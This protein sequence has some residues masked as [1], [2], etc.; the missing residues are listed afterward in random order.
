MAR[1]P[2]PAESDRG[3]SAVARRF[4][5]AAVVCMAAVVVVTVTAGVS[6]LEG[7]RVYQPP[8]AALP[9]GVLALAAT[10]AL[11]APMV[12]W[13]SR[14]VHPG[15][16]TGLAV[17][18]VGFLLPWWAGWSSVPDGVGARAVAA[19]PLVAAGLSQAAVRSSSSRS[20]SS[21]GTNRGLALVYGFCGAA[22]VVL[23]VAY[24][25]FADPACVRSCAATAWVLGDGG[26][27]AR[28]LAGAEVLT[29]VATAMSAVLAARSWP[30]RTARTE[31]VATV[32]SLALLALFRYTRFNDWT[33]PEHDPW[34]YAMLA[35]AFVLPLLAVA[36]A[37]ARI[38]RTRAAVDQVLA[39]LGDPRPSTAAPDGTFAEVQVEVQDQGRWVDLQGLPV[40]EPAPG[41]TTVHLVGSDARAAMRIVLAP[42]AAGDDLAARLTPARRLALTN[43]GLAT[44]TRAH[45]AEVQASQQRVVARTDTERHRIERDLH[46]GAQQRL[47]SA[48]LLL[49]S[50]RNRLPPADATVLASAE[51]QIHEALGQLRR[52]SHGTFPAVLSDDGLPA[53]LEEL[54]T[55][56][57]VAVELDLTVGDGPL[58]QG[59]TA[60]AYATVD[61]ALRGI[62]REPGATARVS[63]SERAGLLT[64]VV[65][66]RGGGVLPSALTSQDAAD[67]VGALGGRYEVEGCE[68]DVRLTAVV[69]CAS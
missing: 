15:V 4:D 33:S 66:A 50:A 47:V 63:L 24:Q 67:R 19:T 25:P 55:E 65:Q 11:A 6:A 31:A 18:A 61:A 9:S 59:A 38:S 34:P 53:A 32:S 5:A 60:A 58:R 46:D 49:G 57:D 12:A 14:A 41:S 2:A 48:A 8:E 10:V 62:S 29:L 26:F 1:V 36:A 44:V 64:V 13:R 52:L 30:A 54:L 68:G 35:T 37:T 27:T 23:L 43:A 7:S 3:Q 51:A 28:A 22:A 45:L 20:C 21:R 69:P 39:H 17:A 56:L 40:A 42:G 16:A